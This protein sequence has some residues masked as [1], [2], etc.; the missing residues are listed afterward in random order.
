MLIEE[1]IAAF[2]AP[3]RAVNDYFGHVSRTVSQ[4]LVSFGRFLRSKSDIRSWH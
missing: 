1:V 3:F 2:E 4:F